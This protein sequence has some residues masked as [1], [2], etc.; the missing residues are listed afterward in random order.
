M[1]T[2]DQLR[3]VIRGSLKPRGPWTLAKLA[4]RADIN[5]AHLYDLYSG[6]RNNPTLAT[7]DKLADVLGFDTQFVKRKG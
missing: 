4:R 7:V 5:H 3:D 6:K 2:I 1:T